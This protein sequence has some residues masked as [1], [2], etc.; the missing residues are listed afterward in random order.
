VFK[1]GKAVALLVLAAAMLHLLQ[2]GAL[3]RMVGRLGEL[4]LA[5]GWRPMMHVI[6]WVMQLSPRKIIL[7]GIL[8]CAYALLYATEGIGL[9]LQKR[10]AEYLT[11]VATAS[12]IPFEIWELTRGLSVLKATALAINI[13]IVVYLWYVIR[14][15]RNRS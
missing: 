13:A 8:A 5:A 4:P 9:W 11:T 7:A 10:W 14:V 6:N 15:D 1:L 2:P 12:L 3:D